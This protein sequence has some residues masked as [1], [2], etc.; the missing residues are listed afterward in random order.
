MHGYF[1]NIRLYNQAKSVAEPFAFAE[2]RKK[3]LHEKIYLKRV[4]SRVPMPIASIVNKDL[5]EKLQ[6]NK[7]ELNIKNKKKQKSLENKETPSILIDTRFQSLFTNLDMQIDANHKYFK[8]IAPLVSRLNKQ[9]AVE[10]ESISNEN[11]EEEREDNLIDDIL[12]SE[13]EKETTHRKTKLILHLHMAANN[14]LT[15]RQVRKFDEDTT[16]ALE[17]D[18][19]YLQ[20]MMSDEENKYKKYRLWD[21]EGPV[22]H[23]YLK[24]HLTSNW[25]IYDDD[26]ELIDLFWKWKQI[27]EDETIDVTI[28]N[29][30]QST[31]NMNPY[32][33]LVW[34]VW[35][36]FLRKSIREWNPREPDDLIDFI[37]RWIPYLP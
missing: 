14:M 37:E 36:P 5:A 34:D 32:H 26:Q 9:T 21:L 6:Q 29:S 10:D 15:D 35:M 24:E 25:N 8:S 27:L 2:Y 20:K 11:E 17:H 16:V 1:M 12:T 3:K 33:R 28:D 22:L 31:E 7:S 19:S 18:S 4:K 30:I 13:E 23:G